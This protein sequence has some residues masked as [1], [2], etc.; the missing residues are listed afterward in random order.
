MIE[1]RKSIY[2]SDPTPLLL[3]GLGLIAN[4]D[5]LK[6]GNSLEVRK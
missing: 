1:L 6:I 3:L 4:I 5:I 2:P